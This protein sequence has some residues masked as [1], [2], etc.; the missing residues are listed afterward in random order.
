MLFIDYFKY[1]ELNY[2]ER[3]KEIQLG[4]FLFSLGFG[5]F[6]IYWFILVTNRRMSEFRDGGLGSLN[7]SVSHDLVG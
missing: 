5:G 2:K 4:S 7:C 3:D 6:E 1:K